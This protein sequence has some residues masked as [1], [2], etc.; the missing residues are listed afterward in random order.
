MPKIVKPCPNIQCP[1]L[2]VLR[3]HMPDCAL[4]WVE[5]PIC[6]VRGP[7]C[8]KKDMACGAWDNTFPRHEFF[9]AETVKPEDESD[10]WGWAGDEPGEFYWQRVFWHTGKWRDISSQII[11]VTCWTPMFPAQA[12]ESGN[13]E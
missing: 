3:S 8:I 2:G 13:Q 7:E 6:H 11:S 1:G 12:Q 4:Y 5:C 9:D 10:V